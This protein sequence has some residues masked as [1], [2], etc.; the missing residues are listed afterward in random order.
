MYSLLN[1]CISKA[2]ISA[3]FGILIGIGRLCSTSIAEKLELLIFYLIY[4]LKD[5]LNC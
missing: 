5:K 2:D 1:C 3:I 4:I